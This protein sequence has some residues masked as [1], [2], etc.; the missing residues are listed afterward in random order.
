MVTKAKPKLTLYWCNMQTD[1][2]QTHLQNPDPEFLKLYSVHQLEDPTGPY[3]LGLITTDQSSISFKFSLTVNEFFCQN[4]TPLR[5]QKQNKETLGLPDP[6]LSQSIWVEHAWKLKVQ[7]S[8][9]IDQNSQTKERKNPISHAVVVP[10]D[11]EQDQKQTEQLTNAKSS[12]RDQ[13]DN[14]TGV[15]FYPSVRPMEKDKIFWKK[16]WNEESWEVYRKNFKNKNKHLS[17]TLCYW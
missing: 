16:T 11:S 8:T 13:M 12:W 4:G 3:R 5:K 14:P 1:S 17:T 7:I 10:S 15:F 2:H 6:R 9:I